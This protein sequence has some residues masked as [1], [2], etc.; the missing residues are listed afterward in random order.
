MRKGQ[1]SNKMLCESELNR[2]SECDEEDDVV[3]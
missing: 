2:N 1:M 3:G